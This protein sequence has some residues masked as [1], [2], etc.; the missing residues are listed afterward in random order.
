MTEA[1]REQVRAALHRIWRVKSRLERSRP[2]RLY[3]SQEL[4]EAVVAI[5][6]AVGLD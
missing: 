6:E 1:E 4:F 5:K 2:P 3:L